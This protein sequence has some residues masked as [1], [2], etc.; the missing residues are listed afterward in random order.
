[1]AMNAMYL[2]FNLSHQERFD[3]AFLGLIG[4]LAFEN[5]FKE[6]DVINETDNTHVAN[7]NSDQNDFHVNSRIIDMKVVKK[8]KKK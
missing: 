2:G 7:S 3:K 1:M 4:E 5:S 8:S 6:K